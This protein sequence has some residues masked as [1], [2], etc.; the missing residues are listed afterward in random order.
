MARCSNCGK[1]SLFLKLENGLCNDCVAIAHRRRE[2]EELSQKKTQLQNEITVFQKRLHELKKNNPGFDPFTRPDSINLDAVPERGTL[3]Q[4]VMNG[5]AELYAYTRV[6]VSDVDHH[7]LQNMVINESYAL[8]PEL[9]ADGSVSLMH[10]SK[11]VAKL[12]ERV[13]MCADWLRRN[14][15]IRCEM[16]GFQTGKE[17]IVLAFYRDEAARLGNH[18]SVVIKLT[19]YSADYKQDG[20]RSLKAGEKLTCAEDD[21]TDDKVNV[22]DWCSESIGRLPKKYADKFLNEG[23]AGIFFDHADEDAEG[24]LV[25]YVKIYL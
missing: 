7:I 10:A 17:H 3:R 18:D 16:T 21:Y 24:R 19:S 4:P 8:T 11:Y 9:C 20:I 23:F 15:P 22:L 12:A 13:D 14:D 6:P 1:S 2:I 5:C 25:P